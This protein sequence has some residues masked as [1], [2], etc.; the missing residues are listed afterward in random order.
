MKKILATLA[1]FAMIM[2]IYVPMV[3]AQN[4]PTEAVITQGGS[5]P[6][7]EKIF[8][9]PDSAD[10]LHVIPGTQILPNPGTGNTENN[11]AFWKYAVVSDPNGKADIGAVFEYLINT[12]GIQGAEKTTTAITVQSEWEAI[13]LDALNQKV[14]T[15]AEY[16]D[17][18]W[19]LDPLKLQ[20]TMFKVQN[21]LTNHDLPGVYTV[22]IKATDN[23]GATSI[24]TAPFDYV[25]LKALELDFSDINYGP[26]S[27]NSPKWVAGNPVFTVGGDGKPTLK[28]QGNTPLQVKIN[29]SDLVSSVTTD[30]TYGQKIL[31]EY[32]SVELLGQHVNNILE[33]GPGLKTPVVLDGF[34]QPCTPTQISFDIRAPIGTGS[35][36]YKGSM[37][38]V[39][40]P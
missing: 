6:V 4:I 40:A 33:N 3:T 2:A 26:I 20:A 31:A 14:I 13:L 34:L 28:N 39:I 16:D 37:T 5:P 22:K 30:L 7:I 32:L 29:A 19:K 23:G 36:T 18:L 27:V 10:P 12:T 17:L 15:Q 25:A 9:L 35:G 38:I 8:V 24:A 1:A 11:T 21:T